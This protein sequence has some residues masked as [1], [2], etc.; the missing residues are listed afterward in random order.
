M[1]TR[2]PS[3]P[4]FGHWLGTGQLPWCQVGR[5]ATGG[6]HEHTSSSSLVNPRVVSKRL[7]AFHRVGVWELSPKGPHR[8]VAKMSERKQHQRLSFATARSCLQTPSQR[9][10][11]HTCQASGGEGHPGVQQGYLPPA[12]SLAV[13]LSQ[14]KASQASSAPSAVLKLHKDGSRSS[15]SFWKSLGSNSRLRHLL[16]AHERPAGSSLGSPAKRR[17]VPTCNI[18]FRISAGNPCCLSQTDRH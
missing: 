4:G 2:T 15:I 17:H 14:G 7:H 13:T 16:M 18:Y 6:C 10:S 1:F 5:R 11:P 3:V 8:P 9:G 12:Q